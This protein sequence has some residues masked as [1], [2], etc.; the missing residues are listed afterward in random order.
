MFCASIIQATGT[1]SPLKTQTYFNKNIFQTGEALCFKSYVYG[2][3]NS[4]PNSTLTIEL[5]DENNNIILT[6]KRKVKAGESNGCI[7]IPTTIESNLYTI[8]TYT[9]TKNNHFASL[10][11]I[12]ILNSAPDLTIKKEDL[13]FDFSLPTKSLHIETTNLIN[14]KIPSSYLEDTIY[15]TDSNSKIVS[16]KFINSKYSELAFTPDS[17]DQYTLKYKSIEKKLPKA[18][19]SNITINNH[20][21]TKN[22]EYRL[23]NNNQEYIL[24]LGKLFN[25]NLTS[26]KIIIPKGSTIFKKS[27]SELDEGI[28]Y[29]HLSDSLGDIVF[30][31]YIYSKTKTPKEELNINVKNGQLKKQRSKVNVSVTS[32]YLNLSDCHIKVIKK[33]N[34]GNCINGSFPD[35]LL[36]MFPELGKKDAPN[37]YFETIFSFIDEKELQSI[38]SIATFN[39]NIAYVNKINNTQNTVELFDLE[40]KESV[41]IKTVNGNL[42]IEKP[43]F[44]K[45]QFHL[46][47]D[48]NQIENSIVQSHNNIEFDNYIK[49]SKKAFLTKYHDLLLDKYKRRKIQTIFYFLPLTFNNDTINN[50][51]DV[52]PDYE[53][54]PENYFHVPHVA[55]F[56]KS[57]TKS[58][59]LKKDK[60]KSKSIYL[61]QNKNGYRYDFPEKAEIIVNGRIYR[62]SH[63]NLLSIATEKIK[64][65]KIYHNPAKFKNFYFDV[66]K[67]GLVEFE[68]KDDA[69]QEISK[70]DFYPI[71]N[72][73]GYNYDKVKL[74][75]PE[76]PDNEL[77]HDKSNV[78][79]RDL[80]YWNPKLKE[81]DNGEFEAEF[82]TSDDKGVYD[83]IV[84]GKTENND[85]VTKVVQLTVQ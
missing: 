45:V 73:K 7:L 68:I 31:N 74:I 84:T 78:D 81:N 66:L 62:G 37:K 27:R 3:N 52:D 47:T 63:E 6:E 70:N 33:G 30:K 36:L 60:N 35:H 55:K 40:H 44:E 29:L 28:W 83:V 22:I 39:P 24:T 65:I 71:I 46:L 69:F 23:Q 51:I 38:K 16:K 19:K 48:I 67:S 2:N 26:T 21:D 72:I 85:F 80:L 77:K 58:T 9:N 42:Q 11:S 25:D 1:Q 61:F 59:L 64:T 50:K 14:L 32:N 12:Y 13:T 20:S 8:R 18:I 17:S 4:T 56:L 34:Y 5:I 79:F 75:F 82:Y 53:Y 57:Y 49:N 43:N 41:S 76:Y 54:V 10:S 15:I